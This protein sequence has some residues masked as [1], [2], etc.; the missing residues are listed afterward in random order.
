MRLTSEDTKKTEQYQ[1]EARRSEL[2][3]SALTLEEYLKSLEMKLTIREIEENDIARA[4]QLT[5]KTNQ[6]NLTTRRYTESDIRE[7]KDAPN[8]RVWIGELEDK[9]G[10]YG[11][12]ILAIVKIEGEKAVI[13]TF[14]MSCRVMGRNVETDFLAYIEKELVKDGLRE[15]IGEYIPTLKNS[16]VS[17]FWEDTGY[18]TNQ[19][20]NN[21]IS[22]IH[23]V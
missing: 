2:K 11:K 23:K 18:I 22:F 4:A 17:T 3:K 21:V 6:F 15:I 16:I 13:D 1:L 9:F 7:I 14:L 5:Q 19:I 10:S 20:K 12:V 8:Y